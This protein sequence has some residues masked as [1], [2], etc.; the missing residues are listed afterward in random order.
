MSS[1]LLDP[2]QTFKDEW[3][4]YSKKIELK[5]NLDKF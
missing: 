1:F 5:V 2:V 3:Q 4:N